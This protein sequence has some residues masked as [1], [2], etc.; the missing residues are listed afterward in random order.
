MTP[1]PASHA[2]IINLDRSPERLATISARLDT[3]GI[4]WTRIQAVDGNS[5]GAPPWPNHDFAGF[6]RHFGK[7]PG[8]GELGCYL[9]HVEAM[10]TFLR[11]DYETALILEDDAALPD[12]LPAILDELE[13]MASQWDVVTLSGFHRAL[14]RTN[15][16]MASGRKLVTFFGPQRGAAAYLVS[17]KAAESYSRLLLP[18]H[19]PYDHE[20]DKAWRYGIRFRGLVPFPVRPDRS[21][22]T[23]GH[24]KRRKK[25]WYRRT[26]VL[27]YRIGL[28][29]NRWRYN[30]FTDTDW[31]RFRG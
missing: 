31:M 17:R 30:L 3:L 6:D 22:S 24:G 1:V 18:M 14:P 19:V 29:I 20:F 8:K 4:G 7:P 11:D 28:E 12:D 9:S 16:N 5:F 10:R 15:A 21:P 26:S 13:A 25:V 23:I 2:Y 27:F